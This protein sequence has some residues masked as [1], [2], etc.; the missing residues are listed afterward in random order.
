MTEARAPP[1]AAAPAGAHSASAAIPALRIVSSARCLRISIVNTLI[2][3]SDRFEDG[4]QT[5]ADT[6]A[7]GRD[8]ILAAAALQLAD[9]GAGEA[10]AGAAERVA[11]GDRAAVDVEAL[12]LD[13]E[14]ASAGEDLRGE[15][16]AQLDQVELVDRQAGV[17][18]RAGDGLDRPDAHEGGVDPRDTGGDHPRQRLGADLLDAFLG[19][20]Q[21]AGGA[22]VQGRGVA[23]GDRPPLAKDRSQ[24]LQLLQGG[25][26]ARSL[27]GLDEGGL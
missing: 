18:Q 17:L 4:G 26:G 15:G 8:P 19:G 25:I 2:E 1:E 14:L 22:V 10:G 13:P 27:V 6:D 3:R 12:L 16:L 7:E 24:L 11:E 21:H 9:Q 20:D 5:L 23:G